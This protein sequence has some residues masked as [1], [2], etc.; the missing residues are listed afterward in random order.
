MMV[1][2]CGVDGSKSEWCVVLRRLGTKEF[3]THLVPFQ[4][5][6]KLPENPKVIAVDLPIGLPEVTMPGGRRCDCLAR[7]RL[8]WRRAR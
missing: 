6:L 5:L 3:H 4:A 7:D 2:V 1:W 8:G